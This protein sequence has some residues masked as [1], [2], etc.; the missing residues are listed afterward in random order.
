MHRAELFFIALSGLIASAALA[1][2]RPNIVLIMVDD[3]GYSE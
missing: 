1:G 3:L 2:D